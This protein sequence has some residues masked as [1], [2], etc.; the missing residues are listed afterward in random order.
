MLVTGGAGYIG[1]F[2]VRALLAAGF[3]VVVVDDLS[4]G[5]REA[6]ELG[7]ELVELDLRERER[8]GAVLARGFEGVL[9]LA[10]L[11]AVGE[12]VAEPARYLDVNVRGSLNLL[13]AMRAHEVPA[14]VF[15][16]TCAVYEPHAGPLDERLPLRPLSPYAH[17]KLMVEQALE[18]CADEGLRSY[19]LR[20]FNAAGAAL[21][22]SLG[23]AHEPET[24]L[25]PIAIERA[26]AGRALTVFG[27]DYDTPDGTCVRDYVH[28]LDLARAHVLA[29]ER[30]LAGERGEALNLGTGRGA[31]VREIAGLVGEALARP[32]QLERGE[33]RPGDQP[34]L[35]A[36]P[37]RAAERLGWRAE[38]GLDEIIRSACAWHRRPRFGPGAKG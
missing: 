32:L 38:H 5:H 9:H 33:R 13:D 19:R 12:S 30:L 22:G 8:L 21:D 29:L 25:I 18:L 27:E 4:G 36:D 24:H 23:E 20:Y 26:L 17:T 7:V 28:V 11:I 6:V 10:G 31:S 16:S 34:A 35:V 1:S 3:E 2:C 14:L 15:S 37:S